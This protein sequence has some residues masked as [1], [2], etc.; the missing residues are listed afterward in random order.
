MDSSIEASLDRQVLLPPPSTTPTCSFRRLNLSNDPKPE[1]AKPKPIVVV[2]PPPAP[3]PPSSSDP[4]VGPAPKDDA[5][6]V[7]DALD[8]FEEYGNENNNERVKN[9][10]KSLKE[11]RLQDELWEELAT[12]ICSDP[13]MKT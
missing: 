11:L 10:C 1:D 6:K 8:R 7:M 5:S 4:G 3:S 9:H 2:V 12:D 13:D